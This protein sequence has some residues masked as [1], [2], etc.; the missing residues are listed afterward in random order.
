MRA[1]LRY[2][3][4]AIEEVPPP[5]GGGEPEAGTDPDPGLSL[6]GAEI[7]I[8]WVTV[9]TDSGEKHY[10]AG[11]IALDTVHRDARVLSF[12]TIVRPLSSLDGALETATQ[13]LELSD[14]DRTLRGLADS[15]TLMNKRVD[16]YGSTKAGIQAAAIPRRLFQ[17]LVRGYKALPNLRFRLQLEDY[18]SALCNPVKGQKVLPQRTITLADFPNCPET[19]VGT[20]VPILYGLCSDEALGDAALGVVPAT[21]VGQRT[22]DG[23]LWWEFLVCGHAVKQIQS[24]F[25]ASGGGLSSGTAEPSRTKVTTDAGNIL[26]PGHPQWTARV[27][28]DPFVE[29]NGNRYTVILILGP[30]AELAASGSV[31]L[32]LNVAG[33]EDVGDGSGDLITSLPYQL[34]HLLTNFMLQNSDG[35]DP[36]LQIPTV[37][38]FTSPTRAAYAVLSSATFDVVQAHLEDR[39]P[40]EGY[41]GAF[42]LGW[43]GQFHA[44]R[45]VVRD[46][47][48][49]MDCQLGIN[50]DGQAILTVRNPAATIVKH[51]DHVL[52]MLDGSFD[53]DR[54]FAAMAN[55]IPY[56]YAQRYVAPV[57]TYTPATGAFLPD[58]I[59]KD[60]KDWLL[61]DVVES[62]ASHG[63]HLGPGDDGV[64]P[65]ALD[66]PWVRDPATADD[67]A[68][69]ML[70]ERKDDPIEATL[71]VNLCGTDVELG[72]RQT[73][74]HFE[75]PT[76][77]GWTTR[78]TRVERMTLDLH[79]DAH[80]D[81]LPS[82]AFRVKDL[83][84]I[85]PD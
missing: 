8:A 39:L 6:C 11:D 14:H 21:Y 13:T 4:V 16:T 52:D 67:V 37:G 53:A 65:Y 59:K 76:A 29:Y 73:V 56:R 75:G 1:K 32:A 61:E 27:G 50:K 12:G 2:H 18:F 54:Q 43:H 46:A 83:D 31:P 48:K 36:W 15:G 49:S 28:A 57:A 30:N 41:V 68:A 35:V 84:A 45:D 63:N 10:A 62:T 85:V 55:R 33:I 19:T 66:L 26:I 42:M 69:Q 20:A 64:R 80:D 9:Q 3:G 71:A 5:T 77:T 58:S 34:L 25:I 24:V 74:T 7:P 60:V 51:W 70:L 82:Q 72:N 47:L 38:P 78:S 17:G 81:A 40:T 79:M 44:Y 23:A 22:V